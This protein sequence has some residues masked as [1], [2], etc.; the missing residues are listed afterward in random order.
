MIETL[1][2]LGGFALGLWFQAKV[3]QIPTVKNYIGKLKQKKGSDNIM[4]ASVG[5]TSS[6]VITINTSPKE[7]RAIKKRW[8]QL[9]KQS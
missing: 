1:K 7:A 9:R 6:D 5:E 2:I 8:R 3:L 4:T